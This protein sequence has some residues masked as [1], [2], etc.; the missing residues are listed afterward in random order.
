MNSVAV[1]AD[2]YSAM[3]T[4]REHPECLACFAEEDTRGV[5]CRITGTQH[6]G[7]SICARC[8]EEWY[9]LQNRCP[10]CNIASSNTSM[11]LGPAPNQELESQ[12]Q[13]G[14]GC[15]FCFF[16]VVYTLLAYAIATLI[17]GSM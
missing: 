12:S 8:E 9:G 1:Q 4:G 6:D 3:T 10:V 14:R 11:P 16:L 17:L 13:S 15:R 2:T 5:I 7:Y